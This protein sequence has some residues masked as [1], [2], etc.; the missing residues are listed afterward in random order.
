MVFKSQWCVCVFCVCFGCVC[1]CVCV[2]W[3][4]VCACVRVC[5]CVVVC[6]CVL[7]AL[8]FFPLSCFFFNLSSPIN[9]LWGLCS[10]RLL[11]HL[12]RASVDLG[13]ET[14]AHTGTGS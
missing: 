4:C 11:L 14:S 8:C 3:V 2:F 7:A 10:T 13:E 5:V 6:V 1:V 12:K 9:D